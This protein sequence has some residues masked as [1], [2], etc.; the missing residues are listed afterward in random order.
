MLEGQDSDTET[1]DPKLRQIDQADHGK[2]GGSKL[3]N[4]NIGDFKERILVSMEQTN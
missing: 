3:I 4:Y 2:K 1:P